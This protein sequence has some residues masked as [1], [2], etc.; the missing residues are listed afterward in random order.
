M[1]E[2]LLSRQ[3]WEEKLDDLINLALRRGGADN[4]TALIVVD[5][6]GEV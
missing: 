3:E 6:R 4:I 5:N 1:L 2:I